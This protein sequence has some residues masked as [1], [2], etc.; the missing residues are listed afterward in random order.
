MTG[1]S[2][3]GEN[4]SVKRAI[5]DIG[6]NTVRLVV[7]NGPLR[8]PVV[9]LNEK[10][11]AK[12][13]KDLG[14]NGLLSAKSMQTALA[15]LARFSAM[16]E[17]LGI[18]DVDCVATAASRDAANGPDF[19]EAVRRL[20]LSPRLL[21]GEEEARASATGVIA[22]FPGAKGIVGDL[23]GGSL[24]L[25]AIDGDVRPGGI[26]L[27]F[28]TLR[29]PEL[30]AG[31]AVRFAGLVRDGL[32]KADFSAVTGHPLYIVGG[33]WRALALQ[34]MHDLDW[35][36]DDPHDF[37]LMPDV[38]LRICRQFEKSKPEKADPRISTSRLAS[39][40]DA[41][42]LLG[43]LVE[44]ITPSRIIFS[45]WGL[46]E[47]LVFA[48][49][50]EATRRQN[51]MLAGV[52]GFARSAAVD[53]AHAIKI[54]DWTRDVCRAAPEDEDLRLA[55]TMLA[56]AAMRTEP[57]LRAEEAMTWALRK[58]WV[59]LNARGRA[60]MAMTVFANSGLTDVP[61]TFA[62]LAGPDDLRTAVGWGLATRLCRRLT[63]CAEKALRQTALRRADGKLV[64]S[65]DEPVQALFNNSGAK[66]LR[67]LA[68]WLGME[69][70][71]ANPVPA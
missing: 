16:L 60:M 7:Y 18:D 4:A 55:S 3:L 67:H 53:P 71:V 47:G 31:G 42:A 44:R 45:S 52:A 35:P 56:L 25:V 15:A 43:Q 50:D 36:L 38:A 1:T 51:P 62:R 64:L 68:E 20:G 24:E 17:M 5:I 32:A 9:I 11:S 65:L 22:A 10:V 12:L 33:S 70:E 23:G 6:S 54:A 29:L 63:G 40:P 27:P 49:L 66:D 39:L 57:N 69:G 21:T 59:G 19:L 46:R 37:E 58:R 30:R 8:A 14:K 48:R 13:G 28:G 2:P 34:A 26:T 61:A 41:A